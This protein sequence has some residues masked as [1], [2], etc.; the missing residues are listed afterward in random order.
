M[1]SLNLVCWR[2]RDSQNARNT[3]HTSAC[4]SIRML[5][6]SRFSECTESVLADPHLF[7]RTFCCA[8][9]L[10]GTC[11]LFILALHRLFLLIIV[12]GNG[13]QMLQ[14]HQKH[15][16]QMRLRVRWHSVRSRNYRCTINIKID[17]EC[18]SLDEDVPDFRF[19]PTQGC[20][21][22]RGFLPQP[23]QFYFTTAKKKIVE[24]Y[25]ND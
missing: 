25:I 20:R 3:Q 8:L 7:P 6:H 4:L 14:Q 5:T 10:S 18:F 23:H 9:S 22:T 11:W 19:E 17:T 24:N 2:I 13:F 1:S 21:T 15:V 12:K 16:R